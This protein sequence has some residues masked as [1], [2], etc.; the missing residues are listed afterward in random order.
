MT[1][2]MELVAME[3]ADRKPKYKVV[4]V[5]PTPQMLM[6]GGDAVKGSGLYLVELAHI[7]RAMLAASPDTGMVA[8]PR[9]LLERAAT[10]LEVHSAT[11]SAERCVA[12][13]IRTILE[14]S[15]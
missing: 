2:E 1:N 12:D 3:M 9:E 13:E 6:A 10:W 14:A 11:S 7:Y 15:Q 5:E 4:P 8:V